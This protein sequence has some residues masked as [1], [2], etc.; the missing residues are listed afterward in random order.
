MVRKMLLMGVLL[1]PLTGVAAT[2]EM[3]LNP[4]LPFQAQE[5]K[6]RSDLAAGEVYSEITSVDKGRV[7]AA[8]D[9]IAAV[10]GGSSIDDLAG[11]AKV[12]VLQDQG[13]VNSVLGK[14]RSDSRLIC[15]RERPM[16]S[17][18]TTRQCMTAAQRDRL[19]QDTQQHG[20]MGRGNG[21]MVGN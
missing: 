21:G 16:G 6:L 12:A 18:R 14:A 8:L 1:V 17:N 4:G 10:A 15:T 9:R 13:L 20:V 3:A 19:R 2:A 11:D 5:T 7:L